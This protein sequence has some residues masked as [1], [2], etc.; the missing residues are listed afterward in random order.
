MA[1]K[2]K[3][4]S[5]S[6]PAARTLRLRY[7]EAPTKKDGNPFYALR[8]RAEILDGFKAECA[9]QKVAPNS[10]IREWMA[11][12]AGVEIDADDGAE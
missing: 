1:K 8:V 4:K 10:L 2:S 7:V 12:Y 5:K 6:K 11:D 3:S 9:K